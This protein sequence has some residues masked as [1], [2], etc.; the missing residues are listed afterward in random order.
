MGFPISCIENSYYSHSR[1]S[2]KLTF[3]GHMKGTVHMKKKTTFNYIE[4]DK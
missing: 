3:N 4:K 2:K 1:V